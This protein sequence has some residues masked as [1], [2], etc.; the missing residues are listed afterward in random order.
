[1]RYWKEINLILLLKN[2]SLIIETIKEVVKKGNIDIIKDKIDMGLKSL[3]IKA[4]LDPYMINNFSYADIYASFSIFTTIPV[5]KQIYDWDILEN[6]KKV[7]NSLN[8]INSRDIAKSVY[9]DVAK[10]ME[11]LNNNK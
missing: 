10:A 9:D 3:E 1:M 11:Q 8:I 5:C 2:K 4:S 7:A 6:F